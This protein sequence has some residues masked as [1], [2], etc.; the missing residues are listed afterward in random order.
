MHAVYRT[1]TYLTMRSRIYISGPFINLDLSC[2]LW[3]YSFN[4][5][6][7]WLCIIPLAYYQP[8]NP[9]EI[10]ARRKAAGAKFKAAETA[11]TAACAETLDFK[12]DLRS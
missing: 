11:A 3:D 4:L 6:L 1:V 9:W 10:P 2:N 5:T 8:I 7:T 12:F